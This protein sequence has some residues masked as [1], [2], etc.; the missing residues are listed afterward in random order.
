MKRLRGAALLVTILVCCVG[1]DQVTKSVATK[2]L[3]ARP[4]ISLLGDT[5]RLSYAENSGG[6]LS[7]GEDFPPWI[8]SWVF[9]MLAAVVVLTLLTVAIR[10]HSPD[11]LQLI[12]VSL[13]IA[14]GVGNLIDRAKYGAVRDFLNVGIGPFR[15]GVFNVADLAIT[16]AS[17]LLAMRLTRST[18]FAS[19]GG[20][21]S[22]VGR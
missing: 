20:S 18:P 8:R 15:T 16:F 12:A 19:D 1:C 11:R 22:V 21:P 14:G 5:I 3:G 4:P 2:Q 13:F 17:I 6:F 7:F 9:G 10:N